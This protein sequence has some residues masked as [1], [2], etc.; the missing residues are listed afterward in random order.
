MQLTGR[1]SA[2]TDTGDLQP[3]AQDLE[4]FRVA[5]TYDTSVSGEHAPCG[6]GEHPILFAVRYPFTQT[7]MYGFHKLKSAVVR[8][9]HGLDRLDRCLYV[10]IEHRQTAEQSGNVLVDRFWRKQKLLHI[11]GIL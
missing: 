2:D 9:R 4:G 8:P 7:V 3:V 11:D 5:F 10:G 1:D 6:M